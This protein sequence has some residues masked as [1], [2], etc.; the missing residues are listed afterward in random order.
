M[1]GLMGLDGMRKVKWAFIRIFGL[2]CR[3]REDTTVVCFGSIWHGM[4]VERNFALGSIRT[5]DG[6]V[7][8]RN[9]KAAIYPL[10]AMA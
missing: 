4:A 9:I 1:H 6:W 7:G 5:G 3:G 2:L 10:H 8:K